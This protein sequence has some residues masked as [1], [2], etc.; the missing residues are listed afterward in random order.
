MAHYAIGDLQGCYAELSALLEL[1][2][3]N[4]GRDTLWLVG[5]LVNRGPQSWECLQFARKHP[6][7]V[8]T[9]LGNHDLHLLALGFGY[10]RLKK[11]DTLAP[12]LKHPKYA[13]TAQWLCAQPLLLH[14]DRHVLVHAGLLPEWTVAQAAELAAEVQ[15]VLRGKHPADFFA[16]MYGNRPARWSPELSGMERLRL[17]T[18]VFTRMR[19]LNA[20]GSLDYDYKSV[21]AD[22]PSGSRAW[23]DAPDR[24]HLSHT[25]VFGH[26]SAL[27]L[28]TESGVLALD[29]GALW[30]GCLTA[31]DLDSRQIFQVP[32]Q[33]GR[34]A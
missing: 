32:S 14:D 19:V 20:D 18:N 9:V 22:I 12:V 30:G 28:H 29:T 31:V 25:V 34:A 11:G 6:D 5:D 16:Q 17:I 27:G 4:H 7:S 33:N 24:R 10:G 3:F 8:Q 1:I 21:Y 23:F 13:K 2:D 26:W 15:H